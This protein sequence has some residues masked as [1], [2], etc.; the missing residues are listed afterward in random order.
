MHFK[1]SCSAFIVLQKEK[2]SFKASIFISWDPFWLEVKYSTTTCLG[3][4]QTD[5]SEDSSNELNQHG[6]LINSE[7]EHRAEAIARGWRNS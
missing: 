7:L 2:K 6:K 4:K 1:N 3:E 5:V